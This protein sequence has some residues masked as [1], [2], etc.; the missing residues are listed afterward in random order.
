MGECASE[1]D[2]NT[3]CKAK[4][5][6]EHVGNLCKFRLLFKVSSYIH[7]KQTEFNKKM[8]IYR[9]YISKQEICF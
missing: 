5:L 6:C 4:G 1:P 9:K 7:T 8:Q 3:A 2:M